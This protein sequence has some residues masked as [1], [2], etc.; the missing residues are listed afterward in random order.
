MSKKYLKNDTFILIDK[1]VIVTEI[2]VWFHRN[3]CVVTPKK[4]GQL[5]PKHWWL[6]PK[7]RNSLQ[8]RSIHEFYM[9]QAK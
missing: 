5:L 1:R 3:F 8:I 7:K 4:S 2:F 6:I 9:N